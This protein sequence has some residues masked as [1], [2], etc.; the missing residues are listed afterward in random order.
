[1]QFIIPE[2]SRGD[3]GGPQ[4]GAKCSQEG[5]TQRVCHPPKG[6]NWT[7]D[8]EVV[9]P[10]T[11]SSVPSQGQTTCRDAYHTGTRAGLERHQSR[12]IGPRVAGEQAEITDL[13]AEHC[14]LSLIHF[15]GLWGAHKNPP[16]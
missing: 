1:M 14:S 16:L 13:S 4:L 15:P 11:G 7:Y 12:R 10:R 5:R 6:L 9:L 2:P 8:S 3:K